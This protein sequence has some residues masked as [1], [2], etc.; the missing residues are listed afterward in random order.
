[1][2]KTKTR[3]KFCKCAQDLEHKSSRQTEQIQWTKIRK[4]LAKL[5]K[6]RMTTT[7]KQSSEWL[8]T[9]QQK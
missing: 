4:C 5:R 1:L 7:E 2:G 6:Q 9:R 8:E 3:M